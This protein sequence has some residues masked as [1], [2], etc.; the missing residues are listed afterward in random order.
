[1]LEVGG[2][3]RW[4]EAGVKEA[5]RAAGA[6][7]LAFPPFRGPA[8]LLDRKVE[9]G[10]QPYEVRAGPGPQSPSAT[11]F[12]EQPVSFCALLAK[13]LTGGRPTVGKQAVLASSL[14]AGTRKEMKSHTEY[15]GMS[16]RRLPSWHEGRGI[17]GIQQDPLLFPK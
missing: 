4:Q 10:V 3:A 12:H 1:M 2:Q 9:N 6:S 11:H 8:S 7:C 14:G 13:G 17:Q 15:T 16:G 5:F